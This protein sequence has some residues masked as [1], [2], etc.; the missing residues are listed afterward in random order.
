MATTLE[1][2]E[3]ICEQVKGCGSLRYKKMFGEYMIYVDDKPI[4]LIC[5]NV[6]YV[7]ILDCIGDMMKEASLGNPYEGAKSHYILDVD[8]AEFSKE[9]IEELKKVIPIPKPRPKKKKS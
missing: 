8:D 7:K 3:Y 6:V 4:L 1:Y 9:V 2:I 5:D